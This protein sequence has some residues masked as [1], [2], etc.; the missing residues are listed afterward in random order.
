MNPWNVCSQLSL[1]HTSSTSKT[2]YA[3]FSSSPDGASDTR[4]LSF[5]H[6]IHT[7][8]D[9]VKKK[10]TSTLDRSAKRALKTPHP[11]SANCTNI[12]LQHEPLQLSVFLQSVFVLQ[13]TCLYMLTV[14]YRYLSASTGKTKK[15]RKGKK[16]RKRG[17]G[18]RP[19]V[20]SLK[21]L[22][23]LSHGFAQQEK[24][25]E[26]G[27]TGRGY[28]ALNTVKEFHTKMYSTFQILAQ[29]P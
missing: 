1:V 25:G 21:A 9:R 13:L 4:G 22:C 15:K 23:F 5:F 10:G 7:G 24:W 29:E 3:F 18:S 8:L 11:A 6:A 17:V 19:E 20:C 28:C 14:C 16:K 27:W 26:G 2:A 12:V